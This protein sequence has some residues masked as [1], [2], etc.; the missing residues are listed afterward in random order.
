MRFRTWLGLAALVAL[1]ALAVSGTAQVDPTVTLTL[2]PKTLNLGPGESANV[3]ATIRNTGNTDGQ[4]T[5]TLPTPP[6][7][8]TVSYVTPSDSNGVPVA[9]G[10]TA[11]VRLRAVAAQTGTP[12]DGSGTFSVRLVNAVGRAG[13]AT[14]ALQFQ[15]V[16]PL[17]PVIPPPPP[18]RTP[19][20]V[21]VSAAGVLAVGLAFYLFDSGTS[22]I[23][24]TSGRPVTV[25][26][27]ETYLTEVTNSS[28]WPRRVQLRIRQV[29]SGWYAAF[30]YPSVLLQPKETAQVPLHVRI[31]A[32]A[33][34]RT[35]GRIEV[36]VRPSPFSAWIRGVTVAADTVDVAAP[37]GLG[38]AA[39]GARVRSSVGPSTR[40]A[41]EGSLAHEILERRA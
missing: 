16:A 8:W 12:T 19:L 35:Q 41:S 30:P 5:L 20:I 21:G 33:E 4:A 17:A 34:H 18:D 9:A 15:F 3:D 38:A 39:G 22:R 26:S 27:S 24:V 32:D 40:P 14:D 23:R 10:Q 7:G 2:A 36:S 29:P 31:N 11:V 1:L 25:G 37:R 6:A 28:P 13:T